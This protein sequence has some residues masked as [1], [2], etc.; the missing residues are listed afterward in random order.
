MDDIR[1]R[2][3][4]TTRYLASKQ[5]PDK[6]QVYQLRRAYARSA[7]STTTRLSGSQL[8]FFK[9]TLSTQDRVTLEAL[10]RN[11]VL[12]FA[13]DDEGRQEEFRQ[14]LR[15]YKRFYSFV[16]QV[17]R[18]GDTNLEKLYAYADWLDRMLPNREQ[19]P[20][21]EITDEMLRLRAFRVQQ[22]ESGS[23]SLQAGESAPLTTID[24]FG[25]K[26][27]TEDEA[28]AL[29]EIVKAFNERHG[30]QFTAEDFLR[31]EQVKRKALDEEM[32][33]VLRNNPPDVAYPTFSR[34][35]FEEAIK[36]FQR[37]NSLQNIILTD[38][39]DRDRFSG[40]FQLR[41]ARGERERRSVRRS[42]VK[43]ELAQAH[44]GKPQF[45]FLRRLPSHCGV[46][47]RPEESE[48]SSSSISNSLL[49]GRQESMRA[50]GHAQAG[51]NRHAEVP[52]STPAEE[53]TDE[54]PTE[55]VQSVP[56]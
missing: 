36:Q 27:Y 39:E 37:D 17:V 55:E 6:N 30:T 54:A 31:L 34:R 44:Q 16:A 15:S 7:T 13:D 35:V 51:R 33:A 12:R 50:T 45:A 10:V 14:L 29:S 52:L 18:L 49:G 26:P 28:K 43:S 11:A 22:K 38:A 1:K 21:I 23:A 19:P 5:S 32:T 3:V 48:L 53:L 20:E 4:P 41:V 42:A 47:R 40:I 8:L 56:V 24:E 2:S 25:A 9:G 46:R